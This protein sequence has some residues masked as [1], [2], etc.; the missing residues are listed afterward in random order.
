MKLG[1]NVRPQQCAWHALTCNLRMLYSY[2]G[3][4]HTF[5]FEVACFETRTSFIG[6][7]LYASSGATREPN[8]HESTVVFV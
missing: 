5:C 4:H 3:R 7:E 8:G 1:S 6:L 2:I